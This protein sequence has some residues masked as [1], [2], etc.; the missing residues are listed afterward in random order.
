MDSATMKNN[1]R[2]ASLK[3]RY[4]NMKKQFFQE[5]FRPGNTAAQSP[6]IGNCNGVNNSG[7]LVWMISFSTGNKSVVA[8][9][10]V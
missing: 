6:W 1:R 5:K 10:F 3:R 7:Q 9:L 2:F 4:E 8:P